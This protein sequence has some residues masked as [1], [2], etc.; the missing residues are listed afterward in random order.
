MQQKLEL[1]LAQLLDK[2]EEI[3]ALQNQIQQLNQQLNQS[4]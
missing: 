4:K 3:N 2:N 1:Q